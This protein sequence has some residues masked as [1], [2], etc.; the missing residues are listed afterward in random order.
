MPMIR[1]QASLSSTAPYTA[2]AMVADRREERNTRTPAD[3]GHLARVL[4]RV[5]AAVMLAGLLTLGAPAAFAQDADELEDDPFAGYED[6]EDA[7][8]SDPLEI[9]NRF[10]F[11]INQTLDIFV[12]RPIAVLYREL[13][14][15]P[16]R[17]SV[18][19]FMR[20]LS[21][22]VVLANDLL[23]GDTDR[24]KVTARRFVINSTAAM[25]YHFMM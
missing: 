17:D 24:A 1:W 20:N 4:C 15:Q 2:G 9:P 12:I 7:E 16:A 14:P 25:L 21:A 5:A 6:V 19:N 22:P 13:L 18:R 3:A 23:Q 10:I 8:V 11:A